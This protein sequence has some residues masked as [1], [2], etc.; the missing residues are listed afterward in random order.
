MKDVEY[1]M[2]TKWKGHWDNFWSPVSNAQSTLFTHGVIKDNSLKKGPWPAK[3]KTLFIKLNDLNKF[4]KSWIGY[5][6]NFKSDDY[7]GKS[8]IRFEVSD[9]KQIEHHSSFDRYSNGWHLNKDILITESES[10]SQIYSNL[11][12]SFFKEMETCG[13]ETFEL[14]SFYLLR[15][16]GI[17]DIN[18]IPQKDNRGKADGFFMFKSFAVFY[19][20]TLDTDLNKKSQQIENYVNQLKNDKYLFNNNYFTIKDYQ[21]QVWIITRGDV[22]K[23]LPS[24]DGI[25]V[26]EIPFKMLVDIYDKR[27]ATELD[28]D[29]L[30]ETLKNL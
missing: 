1:V 13:W 19:D 26:K 29:N 27:L 9:L 22:V 23:H 25:K 12:P 17:N 5:S 14:Y 20:A 15:L 28:A 18:K 3:A 10:V 7:K 30:M 2:V 6:S 21:K 11:Q 16:L 24:H 4:E 8:A